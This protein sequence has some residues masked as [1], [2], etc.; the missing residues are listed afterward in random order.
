[1]SKHLTEAFEAADKRGRAAFVGFVT[2]GYPTREETVDIMLGMQKGGTDIIELGVPFTDP[3]ADG[4]SIQRTSE[5]AL[6]HANPISLTDCLSLT[7]AARAAGV[8][9]PVVLMGYF[10]PFLMYGLDK[11]MDDSKASG[12]SGFIVVDLPP[13]EGMPFVEAANK[14]GLSYVPLVTPTS[15]NE[16][17]Q[18]LASVASSFLY[19][20]SLAGVTGARAELPKELPVFIDR[21]RKFTKLPLAVGFGISSREQV[22]EVGEFANGVVVGS[23]ICKALDT[24]AK[25]KTPAQSVE[26]FVKSVTAPAS[27]AGKK[28]K[29]EGDA[30]AGKGA[31][32]VK[33]VTAP[34]L[35]AHFGEFGGRY[36][37]ETLVEAHRELEVAYAEAKADPAFQAQVA[38]MRKQYV[39]GPTPL[40]HAERLTKEMGGAQIWLK[41]E[42]LAFTGAHKINN[43]VGQGLLAKRLGKKRIIAETGAGQHG[44]ATATV[45]ALMGLECVVYMGK[46]DVDR[47]SLN[48]FRMKMLGATVRPVES[49]AATLKDA[50]NEAMRDW[51]TNVRDTHYLI[52]SAIGPHPFPTIVRDFQSVIGKEARAQFMEMNDGALPDAVVACVGGGSNAIGM[53]HPFVGDEGV[54]L[55]G[56]EADGD[57]TQGSATLSRGSP[58]VLHGTKTYLLQDEVSGQ[59]EA[60][61]SIS[62]GLDYPGVGPEHAFLKDAGRAQYAPINNDEAL[63]AFSQLSRTEGIIPA[64]EPSHAVALAIKLAK[65]KGPGKHVVVNLCG[66]GDKDMITVAKALDVDLDDYTP[67]DGKWDSFTNRITYEGKDQ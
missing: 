6:A 30:H 67:T 22:A 31:P 58:G 2:A 55:H 12:V 11:L 24:P 27:K 25:G 14:R 40:Y 41:R 23:A 38:E 33:K 65:E 35:E 51:V 47:Q 28:R 37:P 43:A 13:E 3:L 21:I 62:A 9:V 61:H 36:V 44:V 17:I 46:V 64:L 10:N 45:C 52:G 15:T 26:A 42:E 59:V 56:A 8:T 39:G 29:L 5:V 1:M 66:R 63:A 32:A 48:V 20:V 49:G 18:Q 19:V 50:I 7:K 54:E 4:A 57:S 53:F 16:R 34:P 60:T